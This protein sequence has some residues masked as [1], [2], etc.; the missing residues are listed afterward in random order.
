VT[1]LAAQFPADHK[2]SPV[3]IEYVE[4]AGDKAAMADWIG[5]GSQDL[6]LR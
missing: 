3:G 1:V 6:P 4:V 2:S 5:P